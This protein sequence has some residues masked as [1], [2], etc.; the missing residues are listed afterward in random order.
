MNGRTYPAGKL[1]RFGYVELSHE[2]E[3]KESC[4]LK[5]GEVIKG[6]EFHYWDSSDNGEGLTAAKPDRERPGN[7]F[8][9]KAVCLRGILIY[10]CRPVRSLQSVLQISADCLPKKTKQ[11]RRSREG[12]I[13][14]KTGK[15]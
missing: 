11:I 6:H 7:V 14:Q 3:Q 5:Q 15:I 2:K 10:I 4:Y 8:I 1:V 13:C 12:I 9:Q